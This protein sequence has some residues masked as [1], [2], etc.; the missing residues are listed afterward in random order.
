[1]FKCD[2]MKFKPIQFS[3]YS[4]IMCLSVNVFICSVYMSIC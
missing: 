2:L 3:A 4:A 1:M